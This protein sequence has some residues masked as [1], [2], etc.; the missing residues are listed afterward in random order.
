MRGQGLHEGPFRAHPRVPP[1]PRDTWGKCLLGLA[2]GLEHAD[3]GQLFWARKPSRPA[4]PGLWA[5]VCLGLPASLN[6]E[7]PPQG[8]SVEEGRGVV[9]TP[10]HPWAPTGLAPAA[11]PPPSNLRRE[12]AREGGHQC[13]DWTRDLSGSFA[14]SGPWF[15]WRW[16]GCEGHGLDFPSESQFP[17]V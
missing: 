8:S 15:L 2:P 7:H 14:G 4:R 6:Y 10:A 12:Q 1:P 9:H 13:V 11:A 5:E 16:P 3:S 17:G